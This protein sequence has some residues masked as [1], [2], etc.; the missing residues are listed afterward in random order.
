[1]SIYSAYDLQIA[2]YFH[3]GRNSKT[4]KECQED[5]ISY[6]TESEIEVFIPE[7]ELTDKRIEKW[8]EELWKN[9]DFQR[10]IL[11]MYEV[12]IDEHE[13]PIEEYW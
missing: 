1:M 8:Y 3:T 13:G 11:E 4:R 6:L 5:I 10:E 7:G 9:E 2:K 12:R